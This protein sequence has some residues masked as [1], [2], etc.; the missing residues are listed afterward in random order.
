MTYQKFYHRIGKDPVDMD[1]N[2]LYEEFDGCKEWEK[3]CIEIGQGI[4]S[5]ETLRER[6]IHN[7]VIKRLENRDLSVDEAF[8]ILGV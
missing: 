8:N 5:K 4:N 7:E 1:K 3:A 6:N 2:D